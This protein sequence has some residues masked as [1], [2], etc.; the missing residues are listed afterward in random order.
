MRQLSHEID[1]QKTTQKLLLTR[2]LF[3]ILTSPVFARS[4]FSAPHREGSRKY[5]VTDG[6]T[7]SGQ[8]PLHIAQLSMD[9]PLFQRLF[10]KIKLRTILLYIYF[11]NGVLLSFINFTINMNTNTNACTIQ[12]NTFGMYFFVQ[13]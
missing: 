12:Q 6:L 5:S 13:L 9:F 11:D 3:Q 4:S 2:A 10:D 1:V 8:Q 7:A